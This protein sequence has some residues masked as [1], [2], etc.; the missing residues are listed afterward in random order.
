MFDNFSS[1]RRPRRWRPALTILVAAVVGC[2]TTL[3]AVQQN[4]PHRGAA[5]FI[6]NLGQW[7]AEVRFAAD[8][9][10]VIAR[11]ECD[12]LGF[13]A[14]EADG[15]GA[16]VR[17]LFEGDS[18]RPE[19]RGLEL[20]PGAHHYYFGNDPS[21]WRTNARAF[22][23]VEYVGIY[24]GVDLILRAEG[25]SAKYDLVFAP[26]ADTGVV[27]ARWVGQDNAQPSGLGLLLSIGSAAI[28]ELPVVAWQV[29]ED[30]SHQPIDAGWQVE[31]SGELTLRVD[32]RDP[33]LRLVIDPEVVWGTYLGSSSTAGTGEF[34][35]KVRVADNGDVCVLG[36]TR[37][38]GFPITPGA[39]AFQ[40]GGVRWTTVSKFRG[41]DG[42]AIYSALLGGSTNQVELGLSVDVYGRALVT[43]STTSADFPTTP[44]SFDGILDTWESAF[45]FRLSSDG[46][47]LD[48]STFLEGSLLGATN[49]TACHAN[50]DG[51]SL[52][53]GGFNG[54]PGFPSTLPSIG[55]VPS[56]AAEF[57]DFYGSFVAMLDPTGSSITWSRLL[58]DK[59]G[60]LELALSPSG[61]INLAGTVRSPA[62]PTTTG[63]VQPIKPHATNAILFVM[64]LSPNA[65]D[66]R[67]SSFLGSD[68]GNEYSFPAALSVDDFGVLTF[69][70]ATNSI[71]F[72]TTP[73]TLEPVAPGQQGG[74]YGGGVAR[75]APDGSELICS[76]FL[77]SGNGADLGAPS[78]DRSG[79]I[80]LAGSAYDF[81]PAT[82][83][84]GDEQYGP[85]GEFQI[86][87][88]DPYGR[89]LLH[90]R[91]FGGPA[92]KLVYSTAVHPSRM[93]SLVG[94]VQS[95][96]GMP[97]TP[98]A[99]Q[100]NYAGGVLDAFVMTL[101]L[102]VDG[103]TPI[104]D[105]T[106]ACHGPI[107]TEAWRSPA[108]GA[109]DFG[110]YCSG[111]PENARGALLIGRAASTPTMFGG[112]T[113]HVDR[114][115]GFRARRV[116]SD[117]YGY[118]EMELPVPL[119]TPGATFTA[120]FLFQN[121]GACQEGTR[122][123]SS[124]AVQ[125]VVQ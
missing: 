24:P 18:A 101:D 55:H 122:Y 2:P 31:A 45:A 77:S 92:P 96:G 63:V 79:V 72:P 71:T 39:F 23:H 102:H 82:P 32:A 74:F 111:A 125:I 106:P 119:L 62:F 105:G 19:P 93:I 80:T 78:I 81:F 70:F 30:G 15:R 33:S 11:A 121:H 5:R 42:T 88:L 61:E 49:G 51:T 124:N 59:A 20:L 37:E 75:F 91:H 7:P 13:H 118:L 99:F 22:S 100:P 17:F 43:G 109:S 95:P 117:Q 3:W 8:I 76:T 34:S 112:A 6:E 66:V 107:V 16:Y 47:A 38:Y 104:G 110:L 60:V 41:S 123:S 97:T 12:G 67:W 27:R 116:R 98:G 1:A 108:S 44:Q 57:G 14:V 83:G 86:A 50:R 89:R 54:G 90:L 26:G 48:F 65:Q 114:A 53:A 94:T 46:S 10:G 4:V 87:R 58:G 35:T 115:S 68:Y 64:Q 73:G 40:P 21:R 52:I 56:D 29:R 120:Q 85:G 84:S 25:S 103:V 113:V 36:F 9:G 28:H 69:L